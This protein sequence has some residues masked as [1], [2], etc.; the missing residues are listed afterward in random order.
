MNRSACKLTY[1]FQHCPYLAS[2]WLSARSLPLSGDKK[3]SVLSACEKLILRLICIRNAKT[4]SCMHLPPNLVL[5]WTMSWVLKLQCCLVTTADVRLLSCAPPFGWAAVFTITLVPSVR[6]L[7]VIF[8]M[9][10]TPLCNRSFGADY[11]VSIKKPS[12]SS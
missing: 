2:R 9:A 10:A 8:K 3:I 7:C 12:N 11:W 6:R 5:G 1:N 4:G